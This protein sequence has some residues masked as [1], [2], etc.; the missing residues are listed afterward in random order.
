MSFR[1]EVQT[2]DSGEWYPNGLRFATEEEA[3]RYVKELATRWL[4]VRDRRVV[5]SK[6]P[7]NYELTSDG[8][9]KRVK[10]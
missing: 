4:L 3:Q 1:P 7:V 8:A 5:P 6:D 10:E 2:D 9:L